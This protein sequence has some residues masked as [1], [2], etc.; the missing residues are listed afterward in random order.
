MLRAGQFGV[1]I[2]V[3][4]R[5]FCLF[6]NFQTDSYST[7]TRAFSRGWSGR[8][9]KLTTHFL[10]APNLRMSGAISPYLYAFM[11]WEDSGHS[12]G[13]KERNIRYERFSAG[14]TASS[15]F[16]TCLVTSTPLWWWTPPPITVA[17]A[18][19][20]GN[21]LSCYEQEQLNFL[22]WVMAEVL[23]MFL[24]SLENN[25]LIR[26]QNRSRPL[27]FL[28][29]VMYLSLCSSVFFVFTWFP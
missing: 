21:T 11:A 18:G 17:A 6:R 20:F 4:A 12:S 5:D 24:Y 19:A 29:F 22:Y 16:S 15:V 9:V 23:V 27:P 13:Y 7:R 2:A 1:L 14:A 10:L 28:S 3:G 25:L 26:A 8:C